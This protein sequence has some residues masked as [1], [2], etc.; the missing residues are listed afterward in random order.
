MHVSTEKHAAEGKCLLTGAQ[1]HPAQKEPF[2]ATQDP[3][4][5]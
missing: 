4:N 1:R 3:S 2:S 5:C